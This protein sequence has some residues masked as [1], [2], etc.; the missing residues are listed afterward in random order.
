M[1]RS[2]EKRM[3]KK[4]KKTIE[5]EEEERLRQ[6]EGG[7]EQEEQEMYQLSPP[8]YFSSSAHQH[9]H[10]STKSS[11]NTSSI[12]HLPPSQNPSPRSS[13]IGR[14]SRTRRASFIWI[15][16]WATFFLCQCFP[17]LY[18]FLLLLSATPFLPPFL[19]LFLGGPGGKEG[20]R[21]G[22]VSSAFLG[23][24]ALVVGVYLALGRMRA[25]SERFQL[26]FWKTHHQ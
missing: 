25:L 24:G 20:G 19:P 2:L 12:S 10:T 6:E 13:S 3:K 18:L 23:G 1:Q 7:D 14:S 4:K 8:R 15:S 9:Q 21:E 11:S 22:W 5:E 16:I 26:D 17:M